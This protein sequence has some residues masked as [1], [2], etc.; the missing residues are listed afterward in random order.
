MSAN[1]ELLLDLLTLYIVDKNFGD[2]GIEPNH[3]NALVNP[4]LQF[5]SEK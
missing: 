3:L 4:F 5:G 2:H 1:V